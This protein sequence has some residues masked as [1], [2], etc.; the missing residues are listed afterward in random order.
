MSLPPTFTE[1]RK[2]NS[3]S[4]EKKCRSEDNYN[5]NDEFNCSETNEFK[6]IAYC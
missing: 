4:K 5:C 2:L 1:T 6:R 3:V